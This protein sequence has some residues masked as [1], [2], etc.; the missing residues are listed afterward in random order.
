MENFWLYWLFAA[1]IIILPLAV[2]AGRLLA[3]LKR[4]RMDTQVAEAAQQRALQKHD[5]NVLSSVT[6]IA[7]AMQEQQCDLSEGC[8]RLSV[9][10]E[11]LK[12]SRDHQQQF[13]A[14][15]ELYHNIQHMPILAERKQ[16][17]KKERMKQDLERMK[18]EARLQDAIKENL[19]NLLTFA[20]ARITELK[21]IH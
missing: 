12:T 8:W 17:A 1:L 2:Y 20:D 7:K 19:T 10:L 6:I 4:Q 5:A 16:L 14:I 11:S 15:F 3:R 9:L 21:T 13:P 18:Q